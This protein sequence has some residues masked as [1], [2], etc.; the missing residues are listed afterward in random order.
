MSVVVASR[1]AYIKRFAIL[2]SADAPLA[3]NFFFFNERPGYEATSWSDG[4][5][6]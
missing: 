1:T 5:F 6:V 2:S 4:P 3:V